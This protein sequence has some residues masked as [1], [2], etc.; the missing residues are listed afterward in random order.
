MTGQHTI[1]F[2]ITDPDDEP[3]YEV[4]IAMDAS[5][6]KPE[7]REDAIDSALRLLRR[8]IALDYKLKST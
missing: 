1:K 7:I 4:S 2:S 3:E 6:M 5:L 8:R